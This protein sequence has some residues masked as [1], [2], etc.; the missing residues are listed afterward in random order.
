MSPH[1]FTSH[2][3]T[4]LFQ[5]MV[6]M[7]ALIGLLCLLGWLMAGAYGILWRSWSVSYR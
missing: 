6:L 4:N 2:R 1:L 3:L 5:T 7:G